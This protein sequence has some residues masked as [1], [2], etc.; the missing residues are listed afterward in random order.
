MVRR[1]TSAIAAG[2]WTRW[3]RT[4][5]ATCV[6]EAIK[7]EIE[8]EAWERCEKV[9]KAEQELLRTVLDEWGAE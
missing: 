7:D 2:N 5:C 6:E 4:I 8:P 9:N 1:R 3:T